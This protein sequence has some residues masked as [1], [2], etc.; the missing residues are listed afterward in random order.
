MFV[1]NPDGLLVYN[2]A[3]DDKPSSRAS[4]LEGAHNYVAAALDEAMSGRE[5]TVKP[6]QPYGAS[7]KYRNG[8]LAA[9]LLIVPQSIME[10]RAPRAPS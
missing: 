9:T 3:I 2:G 5:V 7:V 1:I 6:S 8:T 10:T 4:S